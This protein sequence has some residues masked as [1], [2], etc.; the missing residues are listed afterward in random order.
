MYMK[1]ITSLAITLLTILAYGQINNS[2]AGNVTVSN[3]FEKAANDTIPRVSYGNP[4]N[5]D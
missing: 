2:K 1:K 3:N 5:S 4:N